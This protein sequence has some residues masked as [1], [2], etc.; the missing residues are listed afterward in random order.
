[1]PSRLVPGA[2]LGARG[3]ALAA[4][5]DNLRDTAPERFEALNQ[6]MGRCLPEFDRILFETPDVGMR[7][8]AL[9]TRRDQ[10]PSRAADLSHGTLFALAFLTLA[11][12]PN[13]PSIICF[14]DPDHGIHPRLLRDIRDSMYRLAYPKEYGESREPIQVIATTHSPYMLDLFK[15][16]PEEV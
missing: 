11:Y 6:E 2:S 7:G 12:L 15:D 4:V 14:E 10:N 1:Q 8:F 5:L 9:R 13:P 16:H 3:E